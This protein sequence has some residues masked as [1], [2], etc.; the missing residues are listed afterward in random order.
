MERF[1]GSQVSHIFGFEGKVGRRERDGT[2]KIGKLLNLGLR[3]DLGV[4]LQWKSGLTNQYVSLGLMVKIMVKILHLGLRFLFQVLDML[5]KVRILPPKS[6]FSAESTNM[7]SAG[8]TTI[9]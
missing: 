7:T 6:L 1:G 3:K 2:R 9:S 4:V 5:Q 8:N